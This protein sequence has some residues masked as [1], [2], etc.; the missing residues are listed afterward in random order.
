MGSDR[1]VLAC[2]CPLAQIEYKIRAKVL[3]EAS[4]KHPSAGFGFKRK[5]IGKP[6]VSFSSYWQ[7]QY[8]LPLCSYN[9]VSLLSICL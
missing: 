1:V 6:I 9:I 8:M 3:L 4:V 7:K 5:L 2:H